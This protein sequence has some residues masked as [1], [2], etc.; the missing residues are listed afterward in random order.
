MALEMVEGRL[1]FSF[2][3]GNGVRIVSANTVRR[4]N[5]GAWHLV[6]MSRSSQDRYNLLVDGEHF[7][8]LLPSNTPNTQLDTGDELFIGVT[9]TLVFNH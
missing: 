3:L 5:D 9:F 8:D 4:L 6:L 7:L 1:R 2:D